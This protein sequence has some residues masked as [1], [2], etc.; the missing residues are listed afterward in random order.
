M[1]DDLFTG[2]KPKQSHAKAN[3]G[4]YWDISSNVDDQALDPSYWNLIEMI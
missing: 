3:E 2:K 4:E 1:N